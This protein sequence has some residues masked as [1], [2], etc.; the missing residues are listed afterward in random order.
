MVHAL[1]VL[2]EMKILLKSLIF[3]AAFSAAFSI[4]GLISNYG[5]WNKLRGYAI[6]GAVIGLLAIP[7]F[8][9]K[10][11]VHPELWQA[12][13]GGVCALSIA[14]SLGSSAQAIGLATLFGAVLGLTAKLW[15]KH[16]NLP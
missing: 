11:F 3:A 7:E 1:I 5:E 4:V 2:Q 9:P 15:L 13:W 16:I 6:V 14:V 10:A 8:E 12:F